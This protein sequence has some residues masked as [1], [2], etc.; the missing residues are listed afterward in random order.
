MKKIIKLINNE[1]TNLTI[2]SKKAD[3]A[4]D[5][6]SIDYCGYVDRGGCAVYAYDKCDSYDLAACFEG[7]HDHCETKNYDTEACYGVG[8][9]DGNPDL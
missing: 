9:V 7:A 2:A 5:N 8:T 1:R 4:C 6:T 3:V